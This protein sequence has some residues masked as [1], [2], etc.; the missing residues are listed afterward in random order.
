MIEYA[1]EAL[2]FYK[3]S[4]L[5]HI[6]RLNLITTSKTRFATCLPVVEYPANQPGKDK[7]YC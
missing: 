6:T 4:L 2:A 1:K 3:G 7:R 5:L